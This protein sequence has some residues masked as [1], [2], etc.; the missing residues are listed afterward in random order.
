MTIHGIPGNA[1]CCYLD[2]CDVEA[3]G[4]AQDATGDT[5]NSLAAVVAPETGKLDLSFTEGT[6]TVRLDNGNISE[7]SFRCAGNV[8]VV[9]LDTSASLSGTIRFTSQQV[10]IP[11]AVR[12]ALQ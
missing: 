11:D 9:V 3:L 2:G 5:M 10:A 4:N 8:K 6:L 7:V 1:L 12:N